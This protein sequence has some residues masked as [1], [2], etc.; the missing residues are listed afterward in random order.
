M[1][2]NYDD[3][4][5]L[6]NS[7]E[8]LFQYCKDNSRKYEMIIH[9]I[10]FNDPCYVIKDDPFR[11]LYKRR[12]LTDPTTEQLRHIKSFITE[13]VE[14]KIN[15]KVEDCVKYHTNLFT[16]H[17]IT[18]HITYDYDHDYSKDEDESTTYEQKQHNKEQK[19][20]LDSIISYL[21][22]CKQGKRLRLDD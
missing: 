20:L 22:L 17:Y 10:S 2:K 18:N 9:G 12:T 1:G 3:N 21:G 5:D 7:I 8:R 13:M 11:I 16:K 15:K 14:Q 4:D 6:L 19:E